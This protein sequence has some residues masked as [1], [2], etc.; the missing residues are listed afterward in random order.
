[1]GS[2][3]CTPIYSLSG[4]QSI[5][6][7]P[8]VPLAAWGGPGRTQGVVRAAPKTRNYTRTREER[9]IVIEITSHL[10][11]KT[12]KKGVQLLAARPLESIV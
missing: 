1:M 3:P 7:V 10:C 9:V 8:G 12:L 4:G 11:L 2:Q 5:D 6:W